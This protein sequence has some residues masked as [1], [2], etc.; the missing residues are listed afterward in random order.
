MPFSLAEFVGSTLVVTVGSILQASTG[1]GAGLII[2]PLLALISLALIP[3][4]IIFASL[5]LSSVMAWRGREHITYHRMPVL[6]LGLLVGS[7]IGAWS[8]TLLPSEQLGLVFGVLILLAVGIS[9]FGIRM[10]FTRPKLMASGALSGFLG[11]TSAIGAPVLALL[12]QYEKGATLRATLGF[13]YFV[14]SLMMLT[15]LHFAGKFGWHEFLL[16]LWLI[17]G[18]VMGYLAA[19]RI[20]AFLDQGYSRIA[21]LLISTLSAVSLMMKSCNYSANP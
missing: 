4:P 17:P 8:M 16:G 20:A 13:L 14:S 5:S 10:R 7:A 9:F 2:A 6:I 21:V 15:L 11:T 1:L 3:G 18:F 19:G 12:Y